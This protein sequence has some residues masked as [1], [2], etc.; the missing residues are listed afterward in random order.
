M[1]KLKKRVHQALKDHTGARQSDNILMT[2]LWSQDL[3]HSDA[4]DKTRTSVFFRLFMEGKLTNMA[5]AKRARRE[6]Q[7]NHPELRD[8]DIYEARHKI[9]EEYRDRYSSRYNFIGRE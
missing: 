8:K 5:S 9:A 1:D 2:I 6:I 4:K 7:K 3:Y